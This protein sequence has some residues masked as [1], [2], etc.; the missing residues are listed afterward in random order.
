MNMDYKPNPKRTINIVL[1]LLLIIFN[2]KCGIYSFKGS[3]PSHIKSVALTPVINE[4][5]EFSITELLSE[6]LNTFMIRENV[7]SINSLDLSDSKLDIIIKSITDEPHTYNIGKDDFIENV[8]EW[9]I[10]IIANVIWYDIKNDEILFDKNFSNWGSYSTG[11][12]IGTDGLDN[13]G[14]GLVDRDDS[15]EFG[16]PRESALNISIRRLTEDIVNEITSTW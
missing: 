5:A 6:Q 9:K 15:D 4:S 1:V 3:I 7:L 13:D 8:E 12:D 2:I 16:S 14:D 10:S 11:V